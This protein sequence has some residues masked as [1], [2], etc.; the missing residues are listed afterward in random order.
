[1]T[2]Y[3]KIITMKKEEFVRYIADF[4]VDEIEDKWCRD[5]CPRRHGNLCEGKC[6]YTTEDILTKWAEQEI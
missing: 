5:E 2:R 6:Q 1:M 4:N 3:E